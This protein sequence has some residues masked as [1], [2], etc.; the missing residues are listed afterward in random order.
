MA[1][2]HPIG[3]A[4]ALNRSVVHRK[5]DALAL[6]QPYDLGSRLHARPLLRQNERATGKILL[7][8]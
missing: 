1:H 8:N 2:I 3:S 6:M 4:R 7:R 5:D